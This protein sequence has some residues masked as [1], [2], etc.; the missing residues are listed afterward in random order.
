MQVL[1]FF[2]P[3]FK[4]NFIFKDFILLYSPFRLKYDHFYIGQTPVEEGYDL[5]IT[6]DKVKINDQKVI[7]TEGN[8]PNEIEKS[9]FIYK[10][11][12]DYLFTCDLKEKLILIN[13][14]LM[15]LNVNYEIPHNCHLSSD[16]QQHNSQPPVNSQPHISQPPSNTS[17]PSSTSQLPSNSLPLSDSQPHN[18]QP[19]SINSSILN[20]PTQLLLTSSSPCKPTN[21]SSL[22]NLIMSKIKEILS[23]DTQ[24]ENIF[25]KLK[26][27]N[28]IN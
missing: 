3:D 22:S 9:V 5:V 28:K 8:N 16:S 7:I 14:K 20:Y 26:M 1:T 12:K 13:G 19:S 21:D 27:I 15:E 17:Q 6:K 11:N 4:R 18:S 24:V 23:E 10:K 25:R 2:S